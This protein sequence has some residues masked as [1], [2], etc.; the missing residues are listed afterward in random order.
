MPPKP[1]T[2]DCGCVFQPPVRGVAFGHR[3]L[4]PK[5]EPGSTQLRCPGRFP[6]PGAGV[7]PL[8][9]R[10]PPDSGTQGGDRLDLTR[11]QV[12]QGAVPD[13]GVLSS[14]PTDHMVWGW[15]LPSA[16]LPPPAADD[17]TPT[18]FADLA[19]ATRLD[20]PT[21]ATNSDGHPQCHQFW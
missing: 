7:F 11:S 10:K 8:K 2:Y 4:E 19:M 17:A 1:G 20:H 9:I 13:P 18:T 14:D 16:P 3:I 12:R 15:C 21:M 6:I 5:S